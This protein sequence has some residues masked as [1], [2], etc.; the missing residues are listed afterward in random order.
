MTPRLSRRLALLAAPAAFL[1]ATLAFAQPAAAQ[2]TLIVAAPQTPTGF[3]G[4]IPKVATRQMIVQGNDSLVRYKRVKKP[5]G[6]EVLDPSQLEGSL[7]ESWEERD[8]GKTVIF[9]IRKGVKSPWGNEMTADDVLWSFQRAWAIKRTGFFLFNLIGVQTFEKTGDYELTVHLKQPSPIFL[10]MLTMYFPTLHDKKQVLANA[11]PEDPWGLKYIDQNLV[12]FGAYFVESVK[13]GEQVVLR[14]NPNYFRGKPY[15]ER[16]IY[17]EVPSVANRVALLKTG[18][19]QW[20]EDL[21]LKQIADLK[22]DR[23][24]KVQ[25]AIGTQPSSIRINETLPPF[26][27]K[28]VRDAFVLATDFDSFNKSVFEGLGVPVRSIV[29]PTVPGSI[30]AFKPPGRNVAQAKKLLADAGFPNGLEVPLTYAGTYWWMEPVAIQLKNQLADAGIT[31]N[32]Q[33][34]P[35]PDF[36][37]RGLINVRDMA[38]FPAGDATFVLDPVFT[39]WIFGYS[40]GVAN[41]NFF[42]N[43]EFDKLI[44]ASLNEQDAAKRTENMRQAQLLHGQDNNW[45]MLYYPGIH[46][47]M[48]PCV[49]GWIWY[50]DDWPRFADLS[51][52]K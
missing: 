10:P 37:K 16:V 11:T 21:P 9:K 18:Q 20:V 12:G 29:P 17:R 24:V 38:L 23:T 27:D 26:T 33:R 40:Q 49:N 41:R 25:S 39:A 28:R 6:T 36:V 1:A 42:K 47:A 15:Y 30:E 43:E 52:K 3:D 22:K 46:Q 13:P 8:G 51:C 48:A 14:A 4:D 31:L 34:I 32:L 35:D 44:L 19:V 2:N 7:A 45:L 50:T 5:D